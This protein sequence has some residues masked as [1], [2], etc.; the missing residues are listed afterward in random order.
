MG[1][2]WIML[3]DD[4]KALMI[5]KNQGHRQWNGVVEVGVWGLFVQVP[6]SQSAPPM[7]RLPAC[8]LPAPI[9]G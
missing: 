3:F 8:Q 7:H 9:E 6:V 5:R 1:W 4:Q 2:L